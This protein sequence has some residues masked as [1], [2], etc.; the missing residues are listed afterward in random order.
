MKK[1]REIHIVKLI[2]NLM[3][4]AAVVGFGII[5]YPLI[6]IYFFPPAISKEK[7]INGE[8]VTI[9]KIH[10]QAPIIENV[11]PWN[12]T[13]Y[14]AALRKGVAQ[15]EN[16]GLP[17]DQ[18]TMYLFAHSSGFPW[19]LLHN[20]A[21]FLRLGELKKGD[22]IEITKNGKRFYYRVS[23]KKTI[24]P[25]QVEYLTKQSKSNLILQTCTPI[26]TSLK[27][28]LVFAKLQAD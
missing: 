22:S 7:A 15:A 10:A 27:R 9:P 6:K 12:E 11:D 17:G 18:K 14:K 5:F 4:L 19:E 2:G 24:W 21:P 8:Y 1:K 13:K 28:L 25:T 26:G 3:I 23:D 16:T 20:N